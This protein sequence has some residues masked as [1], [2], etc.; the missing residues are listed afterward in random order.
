MTRDSGSNSALHVLLIGGG[1]REHALAEAMVRSPRLASLHVTHAQNPGLAALGRQVDVPVS[2]RE[3]Y[4]LRQYCDRHGVNLIVIGPEAPLAE[5][6][7]DELASDTRLVFGPVAAAARLEADK[8][9]AK[10]L[11]RS[12]SIPTAE[13]R[14]FERLDSALAFLDSRDEPHVIK[15]VGLASGKGVLVPDSR[16]EAE[17]FLRECMEGDKFG[18]AGR[19]VLIEERLEGPEVSVLAL[20]DGRTIYTLET[21]Q[22]HKRLLDGGLGP[23]TGGMG[24]FSPSDRIDEP[25]LSTVERDILVPTVDALKRDGIRFQGVLY[26]GLMLTPAGPKVLEFNVR[27]GDPECQA[28]LARL[29]SDLLDAI[30]ATCTGTLSEYELRFSEEPSCCLVLASEGYPAQPKLGDV[31]EG[32]DEAA[33]VE[34]VQ[35]LHAGTARDDRGRIVTAGGRVLNVVATG[36]TMER[37][38]DRAYHAASLISFRGMQLRRDIGASSTASA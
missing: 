16:D 21:A 11:M 33:A 23:N 8:A 22:D 20:V 31:I 10:Q 27:F 14:V 2:R 18:D 30:V 17:A 34:G 4:R 13:G 19:R 25:T 24:A 12:A 35:V 37:A 36:R 32:I 29:R 5:G 15:A 1:G 3:I 7:A 28:V 38:R 6:F 9:W 26:A